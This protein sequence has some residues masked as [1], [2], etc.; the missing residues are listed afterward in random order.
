MTNVWGYYVISL[1]DCKSKFDI[2]YILQMY[3]NK[4]VQSIKSR[5][6]DKA[7]INLI[8]YFK[9][10]YPLEIITLMIPLL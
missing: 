10:K 4:L 9:F 3:N 1:F 6:K 7:L 5:S 8:Q 2:G